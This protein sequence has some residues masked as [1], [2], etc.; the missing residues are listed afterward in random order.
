MTKSLVNPD[1]AAPQQR[2][3]SA[4]SNL[5][6]AIASFAE[7]FKARLAGL[8]AGSSAAGTVAVSESPYLDR[9]QKFQQ[10]RIEDIKVPRSNIVAVPLAATMAD[11]LT[12]FR[13][14]GHSRL[15]VYGDTLDD[16]GGMVHI[17]DL[18]EH[19]ATHGLADYLEASRS[20]KSVALQT[21]LDLS[22]TLDSSD[23]VRPVLFAP[24]SMP[25]S[26]LLARMKAART[27]MA[28][29]IDEYG[30]TDG[31]VSMEDLV[32]VVLGE[33]KDE[34][35]QE[36][37]LEIRRVDETTFLVDARARLEDVFEMIGG[38]IPDADEFEQVETI[39]GYVLTL[40]GRLP[41][42]GESVADA[43]T[44]TFEIVDA[45]AQRI[46]RIRILTSSLN[47]PGFTGE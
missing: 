7:R 33:I 30:G 36:I 32:E 24:P 3:Q 19:I 4:T 1:L 44:R 37:D 18:L 23:I 16:P 42:K 31:L 45:D 28:I 40:A 27:H 39:G 20:G 41:S 47:R 35:D 34:H 26:R 8:R 22:A 15:P 11:V 10:T 9:V 17:R 25:V 29:V 13:T 2:G 12:I 6:G 5:S 46:S 21:A 14:A 38:D 43:E